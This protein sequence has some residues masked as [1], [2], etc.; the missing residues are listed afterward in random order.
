M[1]LVA[2][3]QLLGCKNLKAD[4]RFVYFPWDKTR[5][6][7]DNLGRAIGTIWASS[8]KEIDL[9]EMV[10]KISIGEKSKFY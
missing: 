8:K 5:E 3:K 10:Y 4:F 9:E 7:I 6:R 2:I 1:S